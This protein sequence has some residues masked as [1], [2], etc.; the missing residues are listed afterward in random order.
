VSQN[1]PLRE[2]LKALEHLQELDLKVDGLN[3]KK[4]AIPAA[5]K[6]VED[7]LSRARQAVQTK[8]NAI[9]EI[10]KVQRQTKAAMDLNN[11]RLSRANGKLESVANSQ[12]YQAATKEIEQ[13][14]KLNLSLEDQTKKSVQDLETAQKELATAN[15]K[16]AQAQGE[17]DAQAQNL[18]GETG[19][20]DQEIQAV[21]QERAQFTS[22][23]DPR[24]LSQYNR[25]RG[26]RAGLGIVPAIGGRCKGCNMMVPPQLY[27]EVQRGTA[28]QQCPSCHRILFAPAQSGAEAPINHG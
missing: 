28:L 3:Q 13:L 23:V 5:L 7:A 24:I 10:E 12:E 17:R 4:S 1:L 8:E 16:L 19:K 18:S 14:R 2:Q 9:A 15:E 20:F 11:D 26:A 21:N 27:I 22:K 25:V 6:G